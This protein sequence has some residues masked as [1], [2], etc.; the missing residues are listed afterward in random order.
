M[1]QLVEQLL[2]KLSYLPDALQ[3]RLA[4]RWMKELE[5]GDGVPGEQT[6]D[7]STANRTLGLG[8]GRGTFYMADD[9]DDPLPDRFWLGD[10]E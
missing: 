2:V 9:F 3:N 10:D 8:V 1:T 4:S 5:G 7:L 6:P